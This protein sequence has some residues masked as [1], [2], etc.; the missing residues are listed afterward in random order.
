M[1]LKRY[2]RFSSFIKYNEFFNRSKEIKLLKSV[3]ERKPQLTI[4]SGGN[5]TGK[6]SL[7]NNVLYKESF[8]KKLNLVHIDF[9]NHLCNNEVDLANAFQKNVLKTF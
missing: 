7:I 2:K 4:I 5:D 3:L 6:S 1:F 9:R 8:E